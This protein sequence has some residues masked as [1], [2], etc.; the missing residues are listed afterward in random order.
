MDQIANL[1]FE[2]LKDSDR[3]VSSGMWM[4]KAGD[5]ILVRDADEVTEE[6][7]RR[8]TNRTGGGGV[9][10][11]SGGTTREAGLHIMTHAE[12]EAKAAE[13]AAKAES[14]AVAE[15]AEAADAADG[16]GSN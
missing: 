11:S 15:A 2:K 4:L 12:R 7:R 10:G 3:P 13:E 14:A 5:T 6:V 8:P 1:R 9:G 16:D